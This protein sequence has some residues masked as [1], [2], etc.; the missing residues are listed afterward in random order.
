MW[1]TEV[2][3][4][5]TATPQE[6]LTIWTD[7]AHWNRRDA[8]IATSSLPGTFETGITGVIKPKN[9]SRTKFSI[10][11]CTA[12]KSFTNRTVL[13]LCKVD[14]IHEINTVNNETIITHGIEITGLLT[15]LFVS[16][17]GRPQEKNLYL[18]VESLLKIAEENK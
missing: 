6:I 10:V 13:P 12:N 14:F 11:E 5:T 8:D 4:K 1:K 3:R 9:G 2:S 18:A 17:I 7:V 16:L 15:P